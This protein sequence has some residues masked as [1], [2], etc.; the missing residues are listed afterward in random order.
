VLLN[1]KFALQFQEKRASFGTCVCTK[2]TK[3]QKKPAIASL[4]RIPY[5][6][7]FVLCGNPLPQLKNIVDSLTFQSAL[8]RVAPQERLSGIC[9]I[10][11]IPSDFV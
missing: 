6:T 9:K 7:S 10:Q 2:R 8:M 5:I 3:K 1:R 11:T 4:L